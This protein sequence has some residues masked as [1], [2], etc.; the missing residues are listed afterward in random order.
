MIIQTGEIFSNQNSHGKHFAELSQLFVGKCVNLFTSIRFSASLPRTHIWIRNFS[1]FSVCKCKNCHYAG[2]SCS[3]RKSH[4]NSKTFG[5]HHTE[6]R[7]CYV[8]VIGPKRYRSLKLRT[9]TICPSKQ[10]SS[11]S[12]WTFE[13][14]PSLCALYAPVCS[15]ILYW[16]TA[17]ALSGVPPSMIYTCFAICFSDVKF[18]KPNIRLGVC[19]NSIRSHSQS[20]LCA[21]FEMKKSC[22]FCFSSF[23]LSQFLYTRFN[24]YWRTQGENDWFVE[25]KSIKIMWSVHKTRLYK[26]AEQISMYTVYVHVQPI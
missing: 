7:K 2:C 21:E 18:A 3:T 9:T 25:L 4:K 12:V 23:S 15:Y 6:K 11:C 14:F 16:I 13:L 20:A 24:Y 1:G 10:E 5:Y 22:S 19:E 26:C 8:Y 17:L